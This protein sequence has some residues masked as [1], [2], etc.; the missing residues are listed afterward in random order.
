MG[1]ST[2]FFFRNQLIQKTTQVIVIVVHDVVD[3]R[4]EDCFGFCGNIVDKA[5]E[6][7]VFEIDDQITVLRGSGIEWS[8]VE[9]ALGTSRA[10]FRPRGG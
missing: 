2:D 7:N 9:A 10:P 8:Y 6:L 1:G 5:I 4:F 3:D